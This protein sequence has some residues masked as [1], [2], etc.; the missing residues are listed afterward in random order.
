M[1]MSSPKSS[2][3]C[4]CALTNARDFTESHAE[5]ACKEAKSTCAGAD[6]PPEE[7]EL[8]E[9]GT[10]AG[11]S[12]DIFVGFTQVS[13]DAFECEDFNRA[14]RFLSFFLSLEEREQPPLSKTHMILYE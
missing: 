1:M 7:E 3:S 6:L 14:L 4:W 12:V 10:A 2:V 8:L 11:A 5:R 9:E 13:M